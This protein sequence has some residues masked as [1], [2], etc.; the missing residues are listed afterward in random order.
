MK[1]LKFY[2]IKKKGLSLA[3][4]AIMMMT[5]VAAN[6]EGLGD[7]LSSYGI[8]AEEYTTIGKPNSTAKTYTYLQSSVQGCPVFTNHNPGLF[9]FSIVFNVTIIIKFCY[10]LHTSLVK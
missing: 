2:D 5:P 6:A 9:N 10:L 8:E 7:L 1:N 3:T 4:A